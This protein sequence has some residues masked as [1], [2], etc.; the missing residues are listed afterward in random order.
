MNI[1]IENETQSKIDAEFSNEKNIILNKINLLINDDFVKS[2][3]YVLQLKNNVQTKVLKVN[4]TIRV[5]F[6][7]QKDDIFILDITRRDVSNGFQKIVDYL[8]GLH[9]KL[10]MLFIWR[11]LRDG[12]DTR[13]L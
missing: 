8:T 11:P 1:Y 7:I 13:V 2:N 9:D 3:T 12:I 6:I 10:H 4:A 5:F